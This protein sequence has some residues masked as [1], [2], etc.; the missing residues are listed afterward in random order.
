[1]ARVRTQFA[2]ALAAALPRLRRY[3]VA[4]VGDVS[5]ADDLV[6]D[7]LE[8]AWKN[9]EALREDGGIFAWLR[10]ILHNVNI[11]RVRLNR[12]R[13]S[14]SHGLDILAETASVALAAQ[15]TS[16]PIDVVQALQALS[17]EHRQVVLL[18]ALEELSYREAAV[19]LAVPI[20]TVMSRLARAREHLRIL[21]VGDDP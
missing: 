5:L 4:L 7:C 13:P 3:A 18:I 6:Q 1:M 17:L 9:R 10:V 15:G 14:E 12:R 20:G 8:R 11:D 2:E 21:L 19:E 16:P